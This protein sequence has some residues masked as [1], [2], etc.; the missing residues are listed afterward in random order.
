MSNSQFNL[1]ASAWHPLIEQRV[2]EGLRYIETGLSKNVNLT[3]FGDILSS[4][5][6]ECLVKLP[7]DLLGKK[8][9]HFNPKSRE[10]HIKAHFAYLL[11][12]QYD[13]NALSRDLRRT[14]LHGFQPLPTM[15]INGFNWSALY[16]ELQAFLLSKPLLYRQI[17]I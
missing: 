2:Q 14:L 1:K 3:Q 15:E 17:L 8:H 11:S 9:F 4:I 16:F 12:K 5:H 13:S 6:F 10:L 7:E